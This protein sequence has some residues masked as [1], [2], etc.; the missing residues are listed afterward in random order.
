[1]IRV[2]L[3][4]GLVVLI[5]LLVGMGT[6][7]VAIVHRKGT[8]SSPARAPIEAGVVRLLVVLTVHASRD[9]GLR[10]LD[11]SLGRWQRW[12][13]KVAEQGVQDQAVGH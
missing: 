13:S 1:M 3:L 4:N 11:G 10:A 12:G 7:L 9:V 2:V 8:R 6:L 5:V